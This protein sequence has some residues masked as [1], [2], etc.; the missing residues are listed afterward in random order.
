LSRSSNS[1]GFTL[2]E[3]LI[4]V[5]IVAVLASIA[6][7]LSELSRQRDREQ[8]LRRSLR[9]IRDAID[10]YKRA[11]DEG[12][13]Q[14]RADA[15]G[16]PPSLAALVEGVA[17]AKSATGGRLYFLRRVP[18]DP[19]HPD[20]EAPAEKTWGLR[21]YE[22]PPDD[23]RPGADVFDVYSLS[24]RTGLNGIAYREW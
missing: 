1:R 20:Q 14:R 18:R 5:A 21:S 9:E 12:R 10:T 7:P 23:P 3:L 2:I 6:V 15:S 11:A 17:D 8:D 24:T 16:Y 13:I 22:S 19:L 4:T